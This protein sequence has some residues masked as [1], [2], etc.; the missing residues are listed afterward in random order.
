MDV[1]KLRQI[2][3]RWFL[4]LYLLMLLVWIVA[5]GF[6]VTVD[7]GISSPLEAVGIVATGL[8]IGIG[9]LGEWLARREN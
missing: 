9:L 2:R 1:D 5:V 4:P 7:G 3:R 8:V 6:A